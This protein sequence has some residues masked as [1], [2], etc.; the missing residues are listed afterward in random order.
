MACGEIVL[1][2]FKQLEEGEIRSSLDKPII[3][4]ERGG[5]KDE[6]TLVSRKKREL[7]FVR[8]HGKNVEVTMP[9]FFGS[10]L[11]LVRMTVWFYLL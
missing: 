10:L 6:F 3:Q 11:E 8:D 2:F 9:N 1:E 7:V 4:V 5:K